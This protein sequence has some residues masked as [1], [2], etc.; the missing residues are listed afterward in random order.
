MSELG[1]RRLAGRVAVISGGLRGIGVAIAER[2]LAERDFALA[3]L[4]AA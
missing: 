4:A 1:S 3:S 2:Y